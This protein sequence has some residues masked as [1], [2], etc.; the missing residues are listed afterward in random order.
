[1]VSSFSRL[2]SDLN[3]EAKAFLTEAN[4]AFD[5]INDKNEMMENNI[6]DLG[7]KVDSNEEGIQRNS[8]LLSEAVNHANMLAEQAMGLKDRV[9]R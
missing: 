1:M 9:D 2:G 3:K 6:N 5:Q 8:E 7:V 4:N